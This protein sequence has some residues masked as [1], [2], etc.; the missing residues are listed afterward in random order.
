MK[1]MY[2]GSI[3]IFRLAGSYGLGC[4][5]IRDIFSEV[6]FCCLDAMF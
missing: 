1:L 3:V 2:L 6:V 5:I 4:R